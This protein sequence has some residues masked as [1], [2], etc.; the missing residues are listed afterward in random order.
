[1]LLLGESK[2]FLALRPGVSLSPCPSILLFS[3]IR[4]CRLETH[5]NVKY[6]KFGDFLLY[7]E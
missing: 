2:A 7:Y 4:G 5:L 1:M 6:N 3:S